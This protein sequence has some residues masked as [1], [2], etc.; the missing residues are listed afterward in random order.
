MSSTGSNGIYYHQVL[1]DEA[2]VAAQISK[3][4]QLAIHLLA[5]IWHTCGHT[6]T[7]VLVIWL[8]NNALIKDFSPLAISKLYWTLLKDKAL[9]P[10]VVCFLEMSL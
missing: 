7:M 10:K 1:V 2:P 4:L 6:I 9:A 3:C 8:A 5:S